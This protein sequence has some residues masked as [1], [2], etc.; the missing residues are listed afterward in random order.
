[1]VDP[2]KQLVLS[3]SAFSKRENFV[4]LIEL[5]SLSSALDTETI[6]GR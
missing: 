4:V 5:G 1:M 3:Q 6:S 2:H